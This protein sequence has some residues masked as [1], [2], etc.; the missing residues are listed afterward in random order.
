MNQ[1]TGRRYVFLKTDPRQR[2]K[3]LNSTFNRLDMHGSYRYP[4]EV[5]AVMCIN[6]FR[7]FFWSVLVAAREA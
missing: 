5:W 3:A 4:R 2:W 1:V 7:I 6:V